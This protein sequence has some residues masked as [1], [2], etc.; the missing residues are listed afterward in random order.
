M[1]NN[2]FQ[3]VISTFLCLTLSLSSFAQ[4]RTVTGKVSENGEALPG[5]N[6]L[7]EGTSTGT[8]TDFDGN[9][10]ISVSGDNTVLN[11]SYI[12]YNTESVAV[13]S[14]SVIDMSLSA[15]VKSLPKLW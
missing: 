12:G 5:V 10:R 3:F 8:V 6:V 13:G 14:R 2:D 15:D 1:K 7:I 4:E 9:Y 11:F